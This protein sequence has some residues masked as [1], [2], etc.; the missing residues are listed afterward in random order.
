MSEPLLDMKELR[1][2]FRSTGRVVTALDGVSLQIRQGETLGLAGASGSGKSTL[3]RVLLRLTRPDSGSVYFMGDD[4]LALAGAQLRKRRA[5]M[6]M[7]FQDPLAA[8]HPRETVAGAIGD[9]LRIH[10]IVPAAKRQ[11]EIALLLERVGLPN[12]LMNRPVR[13]LS[14][15]QRQRVAL[16]RALACRPALLVLDEAVSALDPTVREHV[17]GLVVEQQRQ[18]SIAC[19]FISHDIAAIR[20]VSHQI[21]ILD[22]GRIVEYGPADTIVTNPQSAAAKALVAGVPKLHLPGSQ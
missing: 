4:W 16:A 19:L 13:T 3:A 22:T 1:L 18:H 10:N 7:V 17:L 21:A 12:A 15:G 11:D 6:Q 2:T 8:F 14:G 20:A 5:A 9:P